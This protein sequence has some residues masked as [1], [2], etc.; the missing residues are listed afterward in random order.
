MIKTR[1]MLNMLN[2]GLGN[3]PIWAHI[4]PQTF[5]IFNIARVLCILGGKPFKHI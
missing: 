4:L 1:E 3:G 5:N 2:V